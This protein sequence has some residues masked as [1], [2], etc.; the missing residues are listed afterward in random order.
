M[1][2]SLPVLRRREQLSR[3]IGFGDVLLLDSAGAAGVVPFRSD[4]AAEPLPELLDR[5]ARGR[6]ALATL[7]LPGEP[8]RLALDLRAIREPRPYGLPITAPFAA[9]LVLQDAA[10]LLHRLPLGTVR[11]DGTVERLA[12]P[13]TRPLPGGGL[14]R[15]TYPLALAGIEIATRAATPQPVPPGQLRQPVREEWVQLDLVG[16]RASER[17]EGE[18]WAD[19]ALPRDPEG[20][21]LARSDLPSASPPP[22]IAAATPAPGSAL[23]ARLGTGRV[24]TGGQ[25]AAYPVTFGLRPAGGAPPAPV[26]ILADARLLQQARVGVVDTLQLDLGGGARP[27]EIVGVLRGFPT[28]D[29]T[30]LPFVVADLPFV[31][32][33]GLAPGA[34]LPE[35]S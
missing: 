33:L 23:S 3:A 35:P 11:A 30:G 9:A 25:G 34:P 24:V 29:P 16:L 17:A 22:A 4:L 27:V 31:A 18:D 13:L 8:R 10:G 21:A 1:R 14:A 19:V 5:L 32:A 7:P 15:P 20:W 6:P 2:A 28:L 26:P 12:A